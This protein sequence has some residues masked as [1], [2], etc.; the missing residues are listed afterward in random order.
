MHMYVDIV[1][2]NCIIDI[3]KN[4]LYIDKLYIY[5]R[6]RYFIVMS[7]ILDY[8]IVFLMTIVYYCVLI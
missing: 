7:V 8:T 3:K 6:I 5:K 2:Y 1:I 4:F